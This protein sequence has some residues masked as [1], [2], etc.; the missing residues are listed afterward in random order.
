MASTGVNLNTRKLG[1]VA[2]DDR[3]AWIMRDRSE[4][5]PPEAAKPAQ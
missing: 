3:A 5:I 2:N 4:R 1:K